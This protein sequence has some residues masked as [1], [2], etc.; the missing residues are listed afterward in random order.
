MPLVQELGAASG[1]KDV[2]LCGDIEKMS[3]KMQVAQVQGMDQ[4]IR[5]CMIWQQRG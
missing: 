4:Q 3:K 1:P 2:N 5:G